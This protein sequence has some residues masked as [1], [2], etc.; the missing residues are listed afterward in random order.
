MTQLLLFKDPRPLVD[1]LGQEFFREAPETPGVYLMRDA[2]DAVVYVGKAKNLR[3]RLASYRVANPDR[4]R[5][6]HL[7]LLRSVV[8]IELERCLDETDA[9][10]RESQLLRHLR[11]RFNRAG[12]WPG[13]PRFLAWSMDGEGLHLAVTTAIEPGWTFQGPLGAGAFSLR[14]ALVRLLWRALLP[15]I[16][17]ESLPHGWFQT[18]R[19][20]LVTLPSERFPRDDLAQARLQL[21]LL[22]NQGPEPF[23]NW[24]QQRTASLPSSFERSLR[25]QDLEV[26]RE[27][28]VT[29]AA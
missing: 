26:I 16:V 5:R 18:P 8:R 20:P 25:D 1:R 24:V 3:K 15:D 12:T 22:P 2:S 6:R 10:S 7:R 17:L 9:L 28:V 13:A 11:P 21:A 4:L 27:S 19:G 29:S 14:A 23:L